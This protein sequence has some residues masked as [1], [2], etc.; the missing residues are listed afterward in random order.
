MNSNEHMFETLGIV[1]LA[2]KFLLFFFLKR[3]TLLLC[4]AVQRSH[5]WYE[6]GCVVSRT[7]GAAMAPSRDSRLNGWA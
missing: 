6:F 4:C 2:C 7:S 5:I 1:Q 3:T